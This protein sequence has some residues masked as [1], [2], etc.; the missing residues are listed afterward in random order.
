MLP[1]EEIRSEPPVSSPPNLFSAFRFLFPT[2]PARAPTT[3]PAPWVPLSG[4]VLSLGQARELSIQRPM[5]A[6]AV[7]K[8]RVD[9]QEMKQRAR[10]ESAAPLCNMRWFL[11]FGR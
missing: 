1:V 2:A 5:A 3:G 6:L 8:S 11:N 4:N 7:W 10:R 9:V